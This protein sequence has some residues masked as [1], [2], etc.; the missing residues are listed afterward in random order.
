MG[1]RAGSRPAHLYTAYVVPKGLDVE[2]EIIP[3]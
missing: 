3:S 1:L 2:P